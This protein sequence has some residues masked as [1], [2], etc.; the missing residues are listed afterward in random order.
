MS[1]SP[2]TTPSPSADTLFLPFRVAAIPRESSLEIP[3]RR[4]PSPTSFLQLVAPVSSAQ[5]PMDHSSHSMDMSMPMRCKVS[6]IVR[7]RLHAVA[8]ALPFP[9]LDEHGPFGCSRLST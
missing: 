4:R 6:S 2:P 8:H 3:L 1:S 7:A 9:F 5:L